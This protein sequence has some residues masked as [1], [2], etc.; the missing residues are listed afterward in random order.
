MMAS[1]ALHGSGKS[2]LSRRADCASSLAKEPTWT[3]AKSALHFQKSD[4]WFVGFAGRLPLLEAFNNAVFARIPE[5]ARRPAACRDADYDMTGL[6][7]GIDLRHDVSFCYRTDA[8]R[9]GTIELVDG[10]EGALHL[11]HRTLR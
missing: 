7:V 10:R 8:K 2:H 4:I 11:R 1:P 9:F 6:V 3:A 5:G